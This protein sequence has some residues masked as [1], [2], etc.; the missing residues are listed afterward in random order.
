MKK[1]QFLF[2]FVISLLDANAASFYVS[3][4]ATAFGI[5]SFNDPWQLQVALNHPAA[6]LPGDTVWL[7][8]GVYTNAFD[9]QTSF[10]CR[11]HGTADAPIIFRN[12]KDERAT[13][14]GTLLYSLY[15]GLG[16]LQLYLVLGLGSNKFKFNRSKS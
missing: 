7:R 12:Y 10:S 1:L 5:G 11:T 2:V 4:T 14:D 13:I 6:L 3:S 16:E 9:A 15:L 8:G